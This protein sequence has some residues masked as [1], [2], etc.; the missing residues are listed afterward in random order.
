MRVD[1]KQLPL[2]V[3]NARADQAMNMILSDGAARNASK[4]FIK[5]VKAKGK[6]YYKI[7]HV[8]GQPV[9]QVWS[10][11]NEDNPAFFTIVDYNG[12]PTITY[13]TDQGRVSYRIDINQLDTTYLSML[14][15]RKYQ[16][17][18]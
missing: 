7:G 17:S 6:I 5:T 15:N 1:S 4:G 18:K 16:K 9:Y 13:L 11:T 8:K 2:N 12:A 14:N 10:D 3:V